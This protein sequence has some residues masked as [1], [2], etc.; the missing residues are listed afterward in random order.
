[1]LHL[2]TS[3][4]NRRRLASD[5]A[6]PGQLSARLFAPDPPGCIA[7]AIEIINEEEL[8]IRFRSDLP[9]LQLNFPSLYGEGV[10]AVWLAVNADG[11]AVKTVC[12]QYS[13]GPEIAVL[14]SASRFEQEIGLLPLWR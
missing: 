4:D 8:R 12:A 10:G 1:M 5:K 9:A 13:F 14:I 11:H 6:K 7:A 2:L 3:A